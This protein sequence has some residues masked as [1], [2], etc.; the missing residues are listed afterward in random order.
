MKESSIG[1]CVER[2]N[3]GPLHRK[4]ERDEAKGVLDYDPHGKL[5]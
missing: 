4:G 2:M 1:S 5:R 3:G